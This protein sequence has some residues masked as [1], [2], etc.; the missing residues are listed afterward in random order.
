MSE[1]HALNSE[2]TMWHGDALVSSIENIN[3]IIYVN[4]YI[5][6]MI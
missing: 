6:I 2:W 1:S 4:I 5:K 3:I